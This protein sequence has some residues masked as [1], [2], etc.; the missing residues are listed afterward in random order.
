MTQNNI[1][2]ALYL[3]EEKKD[4]KSRSQSIRQQITKKSTVNQN[5]E[6]ETN[7]E[8]FTFKEK[9]KMYFQSLKNKMNFQN[10]KITKKL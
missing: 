8:T 1:S 5:P 7:K 3:M 10:Q 2:N 6:F 9:Q 4:Q